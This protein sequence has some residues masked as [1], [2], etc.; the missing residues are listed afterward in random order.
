[1][2]KRPMSSAITMNLIVIVVVVG[3]WAAAVRAVYSKLG[4]PYPRAEARRP[5]VVQD[6]GARSR[7]EPVL[8]GR[9]AA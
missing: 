2:G 7:P 6:P 1:M 3:G 5:D 9:R 8:T 4:D